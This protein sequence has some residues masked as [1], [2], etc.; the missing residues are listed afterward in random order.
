MK[1]VI[2]VLIFIAIVSVMSTIPKAFAQNDEI[3]DIIKKGE[4]DKLVKLGDKAVI[5]LIKLLKSEISIDRAKAA[6]ALGQLKDKRAIEPLVYMLD[7]QSGLVK[8][9]VVK[10]LESITGETYGDNDEKWEG[11]LENYNISQQPARP[12]KPEPKPV[13]RPPDTIPDEPGTDKQ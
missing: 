5:P 13:T 1:K 3:E 7:D 9:N 10:A 8:K 11:W 12:S 2:S 4:I 6:E